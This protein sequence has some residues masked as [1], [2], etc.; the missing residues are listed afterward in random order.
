MTDNSLND[1]CF[2]RINGQILIA[3][4]DPEYLA[5]LSHAIGDQ[6]EVLTATTGAGALETIYAR[7]DTLSLVLLDV[8]L[9][10]MP[11]VQLLR[12]VS[13]D[14]V[15][16][17]VPVVVMGADRSAEAG[18]L[19]DG[20]TDFILLPCPDTDV[21]LARA[22]R[23]I[24]LSADRSIVRLSERDPLTGLC[25]KDFFFS[26]VRQYDL[27]HG[28]MEMDAIIVNIC[29]FHMINE[30]YGRGYGDDVLRRIGERIQQYISRDGG[31]ICRR[32]G[33][34]FMIYTPHRVNYEQILDHATAGMD[35]RIRL[36]MGVYPRVDKA[37]DIERRFDRAKLASDTVRDT[38]TARVGFYD[39]ELRESEIYT[40][41]LLED[42]PK[43][44][45][46]GQFVVYYQ[47]KFAIQGTMPMLNS[48]EALVRW[49]HPKLGMISPGKFVPVFERNGL[50]RQLDRYVWRQVAR[51]MQDWQERLGFR[52]PVSVNV[53]RIDM[54]DQD[55]VE[56]IKQL[57]SEFGLSPDEFLLEITESAYTQD[58]N[59]IINTVKRLRDEGFHIEIDDFGSGY[60]SLN[61]ISTLPID[62]LK[63]DMEF[64]HNAF[65]ERK[66]TRM[67][68]AVID[69]A[70]S[71]EVPTIAEG[72]ET[73]EQMFALKAMGC[74][75]VQGFYFSKP[76]PA[77]EFELFL[78]ERRDGGMGHAGERD[79][80]GGVKPAEQFAYEALHDPQ[81]GLY[82]HS[83]YKMLLK[84]ADQRNI[85]LL[86]A[87]LE[88]Y[89][90]MREEYGEDVVAR[91]VTLV[92]NVLRHNFRSV[93][94]VCRISP[95][96]FAIIMT[97][98][99][100]TMQSLIADKVRHINAMLQEGR[101]DLPPVELSIGVAFA[102]RRNPQGDIFHDADVALSRM[103]SM[104]ES[105]WSIY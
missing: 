82:N 45:E 5:T 37:L 33:D 42:F 18:L 57:V 21:V 31:I 62:A 36:R 48:S 15:L 39:E 13:E 55:L 27:Y 7:K 61:M 73:A 66:N 8:T 77:E 74:D 70:Y 101:G 22:R 47:P 53:S 96:E 6:Y 100:N 84:D 103:K 46:E 23:A 88:G 59:Q 65:K 28:D 49:I 11:G 83:A 72:V 41:Q 52:M 26:F 69:I 81:T 17:H 9:S 95:D 54:F 97:R 24:D 40:E 10:D 38:F 63:L 75:V 76:L 90:S 98:V 25:N 56:H 32:D 1:V 51:Q 30:R 43:A 29:H 14:P 86:L 19:R 91:V 104:R 99:N 67:L 44:I 94:F 102:D 4:S 79:K 60:S 64:M 78:I 34:I 16:M 68:D 93:D 85:A 80:V 2:A 20:A 58:S 35:H 12:R 92:G 89:E 3:E 50:I 71:L 105:G 87:D